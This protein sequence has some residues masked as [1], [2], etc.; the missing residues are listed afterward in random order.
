MSQED[1]YAMLLRQAWFAALMPAGADSPA[2]AV[3]ALARS[4][5]LRDQVREAMVV[6]AAVGDGLGDRPA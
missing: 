5:P 4:G 2:D 1:V 6:H 3:Q